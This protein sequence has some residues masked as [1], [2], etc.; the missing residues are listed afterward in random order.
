MP[1]F[2]I[3]CLLLGANLSS[4]AGWQSLFNGTDLTGWSGD[5]RLWRVEDGV[6]IGET[7]DGSRKLNENSFLV[8]E[9]GELGD[10]QL[11]FQARV[12]GNNN[13]GVQYRSRVDQA[14]PGS[15]SGYQ[16]DLHPNPPYL[17]MLYDE[18]GRG[19]ICERGQR[20]T[21]GDEP[22][23]TGT[24]EPVAVELADWNSY[25]IIAHG[26]QLRHFING[27]LVVDAKDEQVDKRFQKGV[28]ALQL[29]SGPAM[30]AEFRDLK[31]QRGATVD[32][33]G[34]PTAA[35]M[36]KSATPGETESVYFRREFQLP[37]NIASAAITVICDNRHRLFVNGTEVGSGDEWSRPP[38]YDVL[39]QLNPGGRN[40]IAVAGTNEGG[41]A[42]L[43]LR[44]RA[45]L[46]DGKKLH[47]V[48]DASWNCSNEATEGWQQLDFPAQSWPKVVVVAAKIGEKP[49]HGVAMPP[50]E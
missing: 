32:P 48:S 29:H 30:K 27:K 31:I 43:A 44:F 35:W 1:R 39:A 12:H 50:E 45:T 38:T 41:P 9:G 14:G 2:L 3:V 15:V 23:I 49:W 42:G 28:I 36:W 7:D 10:F 24:I 19:I 25:R 47:V 13:S 26:H 16:F 22:V 11:E 4:Q 21:M 34:A 5:A 37:P 17:G 46:Q 20:V 18:N 33:A 6:L 40:V 8:W